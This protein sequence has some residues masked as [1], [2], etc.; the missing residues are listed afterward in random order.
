MSDAGTHVGNLRLGLL[1]GDGI[2]PEI[3][4][5]AVR[6]VEAALAAAGAPDADWVTLALGRSAIDSHG[7]HTP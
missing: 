2:G 7:S 1:V 6:V 4:P 3:V 5:V